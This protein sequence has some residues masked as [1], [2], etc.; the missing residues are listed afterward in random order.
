VSV[1]AGFA[2]VVGYYSLP[3]VMCLYLQQLRGLSPFAAGLVFLP[4]MVSGAVLTPLSARSPSG[5]ALV[6]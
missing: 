3:F 2:F 4:M 6:R 5:S 1:A